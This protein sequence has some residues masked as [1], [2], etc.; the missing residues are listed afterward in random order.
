MIRSVLMFG[1]LCRLQHGI[2]VA[3]LAIG[4]FAVL[5]GV[6]AQAG[7]TVGAAVQNPFRAAVYH[8]DGPHRAALRADAAADAAFVGEEPLRFAPVDVG[9]I[10]PRREQPVPGGDA[11]ADGTAM[12][13]WRPM[14]ADEP[15]AMYLQDKGCEC[16]ITAPDKISE[17]I[18]EG[19]L[20]QL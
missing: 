17:I 11:D 19:I 16:R 9:G 14:R 12:P 20:K 18:T 13:Q 8:G 2:H 7:L 3:Q 6:A 10:Y 4:P 15:N 5:H 1:R